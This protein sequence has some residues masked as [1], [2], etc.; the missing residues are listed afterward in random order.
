MRKV[1]GVS[2]LVGSLFITGTTAA[3]AGVVDSPLPNLQTGAVT[4]HVFTVPGVVKNNHLETEFI[5]T[6][7]ETTTSVRVGVEVFAA[8]GGAPL[9]NVAE[10][11]GDGAADVLPGATVTVGTGNTVGIHED[12]VISGLGA[13]TVKNGSARVVSTSSRITCTVFVADELGDPPASMVGLK[14]IVKK[15]QSGE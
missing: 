14:V 12:N 10:G 8:G 11:V 13:G 1:V 15:K 9:N 7:L 6:S 2:V 3:E 4:R 5:C